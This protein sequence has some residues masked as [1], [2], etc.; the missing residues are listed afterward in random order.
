MLTKELKD[1]IKKEEFIDIAT[2]DFK[3]RPNLAPKFLL[4]IDEQ[5]IYLVDHVLATTYQNLRINPR[6]SMAIVNP[7]NLISYQINGLAQIFEEGKEFNNLLAETRTKQV[8]FSVDRIIQ[9]VQQQKKHAG[10]EVSFPD[11]IVVFKIKIEEVVSIN[12]SGKLDR[13][14]L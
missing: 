13:K 7:S 14:S 9:G 2:C 5:N 8:N 12:T 3:G 11:K 10:F 4:K 6:V 1:L